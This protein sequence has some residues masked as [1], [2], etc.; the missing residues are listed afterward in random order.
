MVYEKTREEHDENL[1]CC[2]ARLESKGL[3]LNQGRCQFLKKTLA[4]CGQ[5]F[6]K[7]GTH[8][9]L[10]GVSHLRNAPVP[11]NIR[12]YAAYWILQIIQV[13]ILPISQQFQHHCMT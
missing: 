6:T 10:K 11:K 4:F 8:P 5:I 1:E 3:T 12:M 7:E 2:L 13:N 9:Y